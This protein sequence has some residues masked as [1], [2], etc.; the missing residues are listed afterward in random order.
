MVLGWRHDPGQGGNLLH[1]SAHTS[2]PPP[3]KNPERRTFDGA[4]ERGYKA[5][6]GKQR[7]KNGK[8]S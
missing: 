5:N 1:R 3:A 2:F 6:Y 7:A 8:Q 4:F